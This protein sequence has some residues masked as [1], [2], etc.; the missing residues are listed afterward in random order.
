MLEHRRKLHKFKRIVKM[1][2]SELLKLESGQQLKDVEFKVDYNL[3][4]KE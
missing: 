3:S 4:S 1:L 2:I